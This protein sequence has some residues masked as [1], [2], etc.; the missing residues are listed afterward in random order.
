MDY[1]QIAISVI[2]IAITFYAGLKIGVIGCMRNVQRDI[3][4]GY[5][6]IHNGEL[7]RNVK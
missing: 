6:V 3:K 5:F 7:K 4:S 1:M 2:I